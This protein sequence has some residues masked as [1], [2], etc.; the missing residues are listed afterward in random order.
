[1]SKYAPTKYLTGITHN[2]GNF[3]IQVAED[4]MAGKQKGGFYFGGLKEGVVKMAP[5][6]PGMPADVA[7]LLRS[8]EQ[9]IVSG[10][11]NVFAGP[12][13]DQAGTVRVAAGSVYPEAQLGKMDWF[14][15][16]VISGAKK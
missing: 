8:K 7:A 2:W 5:F 13:K 9:D 14:T 15:E 3:F 6:G 12:I 16:G 10:K 4:V 1:M 11:L